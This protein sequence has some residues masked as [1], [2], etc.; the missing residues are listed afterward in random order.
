[1]SK[2]ARKTLP[3]IAIF[4]A[5]SLINSCAT[6]RGGVHQEVIDGVTITY[7]TGNPKQLVASQDIPDTYVVK[8]GD[9]IFSIA[10]KYNLDYTEIAA[11]NKLG[12]NSVIYPGQ[13]LIIQ[14]DK[15]SS[16][17]KP[18]AKKKQSKKAAKTKKSAQK[19]VT[20][21][22]IATAPPASKES[23]GFIDSG[24]PPLARGGWSW[25][26]GGRPIY[27]SADERQGVYVTAPLGATVKAANNGKV[28]YAGSELKQYGKLILISHS[29]GYLSVYADNSEIL[30]NTDEEIKKGQDIAVSG[31]RYGKGRIYF[32]LRKGST[33][34]NPA[35]VILKR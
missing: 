13:E 2:N 20:S 29:D 27:E 8:Q 7:L 34:I 14:T 21:P 31:N 6:S 16:R 25:P 22:P 17:A 19:S 35:S 9:S 1:M 24:T 10:R 33:A 5:I 32:E 18:T 15:Q 28:V 26:F 30:V 23:T 3:L 12:G 4:I 11:L